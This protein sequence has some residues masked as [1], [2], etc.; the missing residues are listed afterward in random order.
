LRLPVAWAETGG[1]TAEPKTIEVRAKFARDVLRAGETRRFA[2]ICARRP[3]GAGDRA[4]WCGPAHDQSARV[5]GGP[6]QLERD[7]PAAP[8]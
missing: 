2:L 5:I 4:P 8:S 7:L 1:R 6:G 3:V